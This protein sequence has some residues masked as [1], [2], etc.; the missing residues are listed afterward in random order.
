MKTLKQLQEERVELE[1]EFESLVSAAEKTPLTED[2]KKRL[3]A[4]EAELS[5]M[6]KEIERLTAIE[7]RNKQIA[8]RKMETE[9]RAVGAPQDD[10]SEVKEMNKMR[11]KFAFARAFDLVQKRKNI[12]G[13]EA[14]LHQEA[15]QE[16]A[17]SGIELQGNISIPSKFVQ[18]K[19]S[20]LT[21]ATEGTDVVFTDYGG[22]IPILQPDPVVG[23]LGIQVLGGLR[24]NVQWPRHNG[25]IA[26]AWEGETDNTAEMTP[27][28]D[29]I[30]VSPKRVA[31]YVDVS[32]QM[33]KQSVFVL[34]PW[35]RRILQE[36]FALTVDD[37]V[38][39]G[40][41]TGDEPT[42]IFN[43]SGVNVIS[44]GSGSANDMTYAALL[45]FIRATKA[46]NA[47]QGN[48]GWLTNANGEFAL[49]RTPMQASGV[50][51]NF[52]YKM[53]GNLVGRRF[54]TSEVVRSDYSEGSQ[55]DLVGMIYSSN[56]NSA[57]LAQWGGMDI[58]FDPY[59]QAVGG[60]VRFVCN[61]FLDVEIE[62]PLEFA[63]TKD[64]DATDLPGV[65]A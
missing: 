37:A 19:K 41:G 33:L 63:Y 49:A 20:V 12:D 26:F 58:L 7:N 45:E 18:I 61:A 35:L 21:V 44:L 31:G 16:A 55:T 51:G 38:I 57:I 4:I 65:T 5:G 46:A 56:W 32:M 17:E 60:K 30:A 10:V 13:V 1:N 24:G 62:Q 2:Q 40:A 39:D 42:G 6:E 48:S 8:K 43:Y 52:I 28:F 47:R 64:W 53:D 50:E 27:T 11:N 9:Q 54:L 22:L 23:R 59:T 34:E 25:A 36:R 14:E 29:N 15:I 3:D